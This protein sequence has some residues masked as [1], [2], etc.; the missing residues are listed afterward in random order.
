MKRFTAFLIIGGIL[1]GCG[2]SPDRVTVNAPISTVNDDPILSDDTINAFLK[3][4]IRVQELEMPEGDELAFELRAFDEKGEYS[5]F[6]ANLGIYEGTQLQD[7]IGEIVLEA[8][9]GDGPAF[10]AIGDRIYRAYAALQLEEEAL[11]ALKEAEESESEEAIQEASDLLAAAD[12]APEEDK[13]AVR[14][15]VDRM[16]E[17]L[18]R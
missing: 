3:A 1:A 15:Y 12:L 2:S 13:A 10:T 9:L 5:P 17:V 16:R 4:L 7:E 8:G 18:A 11:A 6:S 14:K